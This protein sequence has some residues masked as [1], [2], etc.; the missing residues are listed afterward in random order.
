MTLRRVILL[1]AITAI[2]TKVYAQPGQDAAADAALEEGRRLYEL[3]EWEAAIAK[4]KEAY[5]L[6]R[7][8]ASLYN[9]AQA[10]RLE[11]NCVEALGFYKTFRREYPD[12]QNIQQVDRF[13]AELEPCAK[14][15]EPTVT[16]TTKAAIPMLP[17]VDTNPGRTKRIAGIATAGGG[18]VLVAIGTGFGLRARAKARA[19]ETGSG[20]W[21]PDVETSGE[22]AELASR[23]LWGVGGAALVAGGALYALGYRDALTARIAIV[24]RERGGSVVWQCAF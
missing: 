24:P 7:E 17:V 14:P 18:L 11:G 19:V 3:R 23:I 1:C 13:I 12:M 2:A 22:R 9:I 5:K 15:T 20:E 8:P 6:R 16:V 4:F 10:Y 21:D